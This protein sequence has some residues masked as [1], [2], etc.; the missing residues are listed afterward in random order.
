[1][2]KSLLLSFSAGGFA[3]S[4]EDAPSELPDRGWSPISRGR[5]RVPGG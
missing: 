1:M 3:R 2:M 5:H 4:D